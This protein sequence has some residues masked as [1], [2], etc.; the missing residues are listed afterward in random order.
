MGLDDFMDLGDEE[1][2]TS[3]SKS[4]RSTTSSSS[5]FDE[6]TK[7]DNWV[8]EEDGEVHRRGPLGY[9]SRDEYDDTFKGDVDPHGSLFKYFLPMFP[10]I[11]PERKYDVGS[12]YNISTLPPGTVTCICSRNQ[13]LKKIPR[14]MVMLDSG[15]TE[16][17][18]CIE[19]LSERFGFEVDGETEVYMFMFCA[20]R[21]IAKMAMADEFADNWDLDNRDRVLKAVYGES[22]TQRFREKDT[23]ELDLKHLDHISEW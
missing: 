16:K 8:K 4:S 10:H 13:K 7:Y 23:G 11:E 14:E 19:T 12:R 21:H 15:S 2:Q 20:T 1:S 22:Y 5:S 17:E 6:L 3:K 18:D 9:A